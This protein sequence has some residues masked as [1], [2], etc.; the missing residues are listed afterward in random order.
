MLGERMWEAVGYLEAGGPIML[1]LLAVSV[2]L[3]MLILIKAWE[4]IRYRR[5]ERFRT[6]PASGAKPGWQAVILADFQSQR[7]HA[8]ED[9]ARLL[10]RLIM[11]QAAQLDRHVGTILV[12]ASLAPLIGLLGTVSGMITTFEVISLFGTGN[13]KALAGGISEALIT[14]QTGLVVALPGLVAGNFIRR[15]VE[16]LKARMERFRLGLIEAPAAFAPAGG[17]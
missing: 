6:G 9:D 5:S 17:A 8:S 1:P 4:L 15:R 2:W 16:R 12:L 3:W 11:R 10:K 13:A 14:T 7:T